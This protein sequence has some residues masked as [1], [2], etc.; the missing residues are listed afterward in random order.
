MIRKQLK[1][2]KKHHKWAIVDPTPSDLAEKMSSKES[3][4]GSPSNNPS[5][6]HEE[7]VLEHY[8][9]LLSQSNF[10]RAKELVD[11]EKEGHK[12]TSAAS[13]GET[14]QCLSQLAT[15][16]KSY[17]NLVFLGQKRFTHIVRSKD[18]AKSIFSMLLQEFQRME[19]LLLPHS[20]RDSSQ[21]LETDKLL[22][23]ISG[24]LSFFV[25]GRLKMI[26][27]FE[28]LSSLG[29]LKQWMNFEDLVM[30]L[31]EILKDHMKGF[32]HPLVVSLK[33]VF[34]LECE[35]LCHMLN[36]QIKMTSWSYLPSVLE[37]YQAH[38]KLNTWG[39]MIPVKEVK[40]S[41]GRS[42]SK[43]NPYPSLYTWMYKLKGHLLS[44][45]GLYFYD[46][47]A[48]QTLMS[49]MKL[50]LSKAPEDFF[51]RIQA[52]QK[53]LDATNI[54][55]ILDALNWPHHVGNGGYHHP[56]KSTES[57]HGIEN[58]PPIFS[59]PAERVINPL[60]W[61][62]IIMLIQQARD[63]MDKLHFSMEKR[64]Q[65]SYFITQVEARIF[66]VV[67]FESRKSEKDS[68]INTFMMDLASQLR[69]QSIMASLKN[70]ARS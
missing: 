54:Y 34:C 35:S 60:H 42:S 6:S 47:L 38:T 8:F 43:S 55:L 51:S 37:L 3:I 68:G 39:T 20:E 63:C 30:I 46:V 49:E 50:I 70:F 52:F 25:R 40:S 17:S 7:S 69:C 36:A 16:E 23:H 56:H 45:F 13:W 14:L 62:N 24:Q 11:S 33:T 41:F 19:T 5:V 27:F 61:P 12:F 67:M 1:R 15:A 2:S 57:A 44:K 9:T 4:F 21:T 32:H 64:P 48:K 26:E 65:S 29:S 28:Q 53:K 31:E 18:S 66:L 58:Y 22:A 59:Y 10:D